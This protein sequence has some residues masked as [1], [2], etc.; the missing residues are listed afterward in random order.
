M[1]S[2]IGCLSQRGQPLPKLVNQQQ[3]LNFVTGH[4]DLGKRFDRF[5]AERLLGT[6][7][8]RIQVLI[9][10]QQATIGGAAA[11]PATLLRANQSIEVSF[12]AV[13]AA[14]PAG[15]LAED[16]P[17]DVLW[18]DEHLAAINKPPGMVVHPAKGHWKG[19]LAAA[20]I[21]RFGPLSSVGGSQRPGVVH[22]LDRDTSGVIVVA[23][24][25]VAHVQLMKQFQRRTIRKHYEAMVSPAPDRDRDEIDAPIGPHPWLREKMAI[26]FDDAR[27]RPASTFYEV[28]Q[29][30]GRFARL[31]VFPKTGRTHQ[32]RVHLAHI[33]CPVIADRQYSGRARASEGWIA[34]GEDSGDVVIERQALHAATIELVHPATKEPLKFTA[35]LPADM[36]SLW[37]SIVRLK[38]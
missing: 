10:N 27:A 5:L 20:L 18:E 4:E 31:N 1:P 8:S 21:H 13:E 36:E 12:E 25:D 14:K 9:R 30:T 19:T 15:V 24:T 26:R 23:R 29:R 33:G 16:I 17:L 2:I 6:S 3:P 22:R 35:P 11:R 32:I 7:R 37:Q 38:R 28:V 34:R